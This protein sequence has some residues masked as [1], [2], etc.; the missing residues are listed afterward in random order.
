M[1]A[2]EGTVTNHGTGPKRIASI[3]LV[4]NKI[5]VAATISCIH[6]TLNQK[7]DKSFLFL[8]Q[9]Q[10]L[11]RGSLTLSATGSKKAPNAEPNLI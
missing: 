8:L 3:G 5:N 1:M 9:Q 11:R 2:I 6:M 4:H 7:K 10:S